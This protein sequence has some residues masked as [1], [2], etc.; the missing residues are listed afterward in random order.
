[1]DRQFQLE[2]R[3]AFRWLISQLNKE[4][5]VQVFIKDFLTEEEQL[6]LS[7]RLFVGYLIESGLDYREISHLM[8]V[9]AATVSKAKEWLE[10]R[11]GYLGIVK[12]LIK[13]EKDIEFDKKLNRILRRIFPHSRADWSRLQ[14]RSDYP[15]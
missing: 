8:K 9:S 5:A 11:P 14:G 6:M 2:M 4:E 12:L 10:R 7:K 3:A 13:R 1:M 15:D